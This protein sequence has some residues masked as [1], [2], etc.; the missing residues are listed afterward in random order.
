MT[1]DHI[2]GAGWNAWVAEGYPLWEVRDERGD[3][4]V[5][6]YNM[7]SSEFPADRILEEYLEKFVITHG[8]RL[9][10]LYEEVVAFLERWGVKATAVNIEY[11]GE[12]G[13]AD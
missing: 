5:E 1:D 6:I 4:V 3:Q 2:E 9:G 11:G 12:D 7:I 13:P 10:P 8:N